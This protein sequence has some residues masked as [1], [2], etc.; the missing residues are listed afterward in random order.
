MTHAAKVNPAVTANSGSETTVV[1]LSFADPQSKTDEAERK[2][3]K[4]FW[5]G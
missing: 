5:L 4:A 3:E 2:Y 1:G